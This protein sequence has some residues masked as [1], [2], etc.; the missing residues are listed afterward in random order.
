M[1]FRRS[2]DVVSMF[3]FPP[4]WR[5][6]VR[7]FDGVPIGGNFLLVW[8]GGFFQFSN[9]D[10][11]PQLSSGC[12]RTGLSQKWLLYFLMISLPMDLHHTL[13]F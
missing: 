8:E 6:V 11:D 1:K 5:S 10:D 7:H 9:E 12:V 4:P 2:W 13:K 3:F